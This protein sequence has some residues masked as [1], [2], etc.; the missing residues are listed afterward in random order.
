MGWCRSWYHRGCIVPNSLNLESGAGTMKCII[1][2]GVADKFSV[3]VAG[4]KRS[5]ILG[6]TEPGKV[7]QVFFGICSSHLDE[8]GDYPPG[9]EETVKQLV[10]QKVREPGVPDIDLADDA[11]VDDLLDAVDPDREKED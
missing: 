1:C 7:R 6:A 5:L 2:N 8:N 10:L 3:Y 11:T 4:R 9:M